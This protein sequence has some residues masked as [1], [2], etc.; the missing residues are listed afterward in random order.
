MEV[1]AGGAAT[2]GG[3]LPTAS[4]AR[5]EWR[6]VSEHRPVRNA[7]DEVVIYSEMFALGFFG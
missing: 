6:P 2:R 4:S 3:S 1:V 7:G 5:K